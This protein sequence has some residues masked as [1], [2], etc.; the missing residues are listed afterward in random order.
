MRPPTRPAAPS[1]GLRRSLLAT[2]AALVWSPLPL[3]SFAFEAPSLMSTANR[4]WQRVGFLEEKLRPK[5]KALPRQRM[6][7]DFAILLMRTS[8]QIADDRKRTH[9]Q[10]TPKHRAIRK[11]VSS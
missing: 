7:I 10:S 1:S 4:D 2:A 5:V 3:P 11:G 9:A 8:Y 6:D